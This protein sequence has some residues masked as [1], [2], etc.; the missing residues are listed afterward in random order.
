MLSVRKGFVIRL[1]PVLLAALLLISALPAAG[2]AEEA[3]AQH[4]Y[5]LV[6]DN[7]RS[8][9]GRHSLG[10]ATDPKGLRFDAARLVYQNVLSSGK[11]GQLDVIVF[12]G[13]KN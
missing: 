4:N 5:I 8:T 11:D 6:I 9:T 3:M 12:C 13:P 1:I 2:L 7:S 10:E